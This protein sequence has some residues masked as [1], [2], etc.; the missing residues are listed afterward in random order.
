MGSRGSLRKDHNPKCSR[1]TSLHSIFRRFRGSLLAV[2]IPIREV[3]ILHSSR[4]S[5]VDDR[6]RLR[7]L[8]G[9]MS[10]PWSVPLVL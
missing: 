9:R 8:L 2:A 5:R 1:R 7:H 4:S 3:P 10:S 6:I